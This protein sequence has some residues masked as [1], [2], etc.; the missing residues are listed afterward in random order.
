MRENDHVVLGAQ[1]ALAQF[2]IGEIGVRN[3]VVIERGAHPAFIL[4]SRPGMNVADAR[5]IQLVRLDGGRG[6]D[7]PCRQSKVFDRRLELG[8]IGVGNDE[9]A[10]AEFVAVQIEV[11]LGGKHLHIGVLEAEGHQRVV[12]GVVDDQNV[13]PCRRCRRA[14]WHRRSAWSSEI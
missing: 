13:A 8:A 4:R 7:G 3:A 1:I 9:R 11:I 10:G 6:G 2:L 5:H 14:L 12:G